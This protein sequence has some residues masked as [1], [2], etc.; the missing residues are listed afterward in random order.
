MNLIRF[1]YL[2]DAPLE[3]G[4]SRARETRS[5]FFKHGN[6]SVRSYVHFSSTFWP[7]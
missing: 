1:T 2:P 5:S 3:G 7:N 6:H 4:V